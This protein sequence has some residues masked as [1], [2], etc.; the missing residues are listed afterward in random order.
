[1]MATAVGI[2]LVL[3]VLANLWIRYF[4][5]APFE[6]AWR[7]LVERR[8]LPWRAKKPRPQRP[9]GEPMTV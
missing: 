8:M 5:I 1:M 6:W 9:L 4:T 2:N 3:L 7:S